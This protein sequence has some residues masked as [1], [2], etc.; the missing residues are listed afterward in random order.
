MPTVDHKANERKRDLD[1]LAA[2]LLN[3][4]QEKLVTEAGKIAFDLLGKDVNGPPI[5]LCITGGA[6]SGKSTIASVIAE[7]LS[8]PCF[9]FDEYIPGGYHKDQKTYHKRLLD[10]MDNLCNDLPTKRGWVIEHVE[11][12]NDDM[13]KAF[14]PTHCL[15]LEPKT[16]RIMRTANARGE[17]A[18]DTP[19]KTYEREQRALESAEYARMQFEE[20]NGDVVKAGEGWRL[21]KVK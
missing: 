4:D 19:S 18:E 16:S 13:V 2:E 15:I 10:G 12:C 3:I 9:D 8:L 14:R 11:A 5:R 6:G 17:V 1:T 21:K 7:R 20:V